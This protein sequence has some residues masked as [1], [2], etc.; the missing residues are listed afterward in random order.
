MHTVLELSHPWGYVAVGLFA[1][2]ESGLFVGLVLPG[3]AAMLIGGLLVYEGRAD[4]ALMIAAGCSGAIAGDSLSYWI[5]R[6][7]G[8]RLERSRLGQKIGER[9]WRRA[10]H[11]FSEKGGRAVFFGRFVGVLRALL[12]AIAGSA[13][14]PFRRFIPY[15]VAGAVAWVAT[16]V[17]LGSVAGGSW[18]L[19]D[20]WAG[21]AS[22]VALLLLAVGGFIVLA[23]RWAARNQDALV[24]RLAKVRNN[25]RVARLLNRYSAQIEFL[26]RRFD[27]SVRVGLFFTAGVFVAVVAA[28]VFGLLLE[29]VAEGETQSTIDGPIARFFVEHRSPA[30][31]TV[32]RI[33]TQFGGGIVVTLILAAGA[34][35]AYLRWRDPKW[36]AFFCAS[37]VGAMGLDDLIKFFVDRPRPHL[38]QLVEVS[39]SSFPSGHATASAAMCVAVAY[40]LTR[41][42]R[43]RA[44]VWIWAGALLL[45]SLVG[46]SRLYLGVHW[47]TD[48]GGGLVLGVF[49]VSF[50][51]TGLT[52]FG[53]ARRRRQ[54][55]RETLAPTA[56]S[57]PGN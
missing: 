22:L 35:L 30:L 5:G 12:P 8:P 50:T 39:G 33:L 7:A 55:A 31:T 3:E 37:L 29:E 13:G 47:F 10:R 45:S 19:I 25:R 46:M 9:R 56:E 11:F 4:L 15:S 52:L 18:R 43:W 24:T 2:A 41:R 16:F 49:W 26:K 44:T 38:S 1:M 40:A 48:V 23:A 20:R 14:L 27:P 36:P 28:S 6:L 34:V 32:M 54:V 51:S 42:S 17:A 57:P 21:R 53:E